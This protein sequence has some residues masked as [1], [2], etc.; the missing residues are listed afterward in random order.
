MSTKLLPTRLMRGSHHLSSLG[1]HVVLAVLCMLALGP[2]VWGLSG[3]VH[4]NATLYQQPFD[5]VPSEKHFENYSEAWGAVSFG[6]DLLNSFLIALIVSVASMLLGA[7]AGY[8]FS[9]FEF[10]GNGTLFSAIVATLLLPFPAI[11]IPVFVIARSLGLVDSYAGIILPGLLTAQAVFLMRQFIQDFPDEL[12]ESARVDGASELRIFVRIVLPLTWPAMSAVGILTFVASWNNLLWPLVVVQSERLYTV[13][14]GLAHF[15]ST[16]FTDYVQI[17]AMSI[18][19][20][21]PIMI[22]FGLARRRLVDSLMVSG[23]A[24]K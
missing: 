9:K 23:G 18:V 13:P 21:L 10:R 15:N 2:I 5:W 6:R 4:T 19:A 11:M 3:S 20:V 22:L 8:G 12:L 7:M 17:L 24:L 1:K 16:N 14:L